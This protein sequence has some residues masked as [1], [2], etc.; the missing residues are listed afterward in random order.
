MD[1]TRHHEP[2]P[3]E[4]L[5]PEQVPH[6]PARGPGRGAPVLAPRAQRVVLAG[7]VA[8][9]SLSAFES[10][11]VSTAMPTV[12]VA[13]DG[14]RWYTVA[15]SASL[16]ASV[17]G[18]LT[19]GPWA[20][21]RGPTPPMWA[22]AA[23]FLAGLLLAGCA[24][25]MGALL[26]GRLLQGA[27]GGLTNVALYVLVARVFPPERR[28]RVFASFAAA[29]V[30]PGVVGPLVAGLVVEHLGWRW[31]FL[32]VVL[33]AGPALLLL[34]PGLAAARG[35]AAEPGAPAARGVARSV[36]RAAV[37]A[38]PGLGTTVLVRALA[39]AAFSGAEVLLPL[40]LAHERGLSPAAAGSVLTLHVLGWSAG[41]WLRGR[42]SRRPAT[43]VRLGAGLLAAGT[44][45]VSLVAAPG[46][47][48]VVAAA[49]WALAGLGM[50]FL[51]PTLS[52]LALE[53]AP[54]GGQG[55]ASSALQVADSLAGALALALAG[56]L[57]WALHAAVGLAAYA[58][59]FALAGALA[60]VAAALAARTAL[61]P[62]AE[63][64]AP[65][66]TR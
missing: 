48:L 3:T 29:W 9:I 22:G 49:P 30:V 46:V 23:T 26:A 24:T 50:G 47:P 43:Y 41:S 39:S 27:G 37:R 45:G 59:C 51:Y 40:V 52:M 65:K 61:P 53:L 66:I 21:R 13:L 34:R 25:G 14:M 64:R 5:R 2:G 63:V 18:M 42:G 58:A 28:A 11:A 6:A 35:Q 20:D 4:E 62:E 31:V 10:L 56:Q 36:V 44:V 7:M 38:R 57:L 33:L 55:T 8:F 17:V 1:A 12:A 19:A 16:A 60:L 32:G 54:D 15:F